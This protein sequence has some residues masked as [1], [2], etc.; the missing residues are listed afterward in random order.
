MSRE[1]VKVVTELVHES[2]K[3]YKVKAMLGN[4]VWLPKSQVSSCLRLPDN[5]VHLTLPYWLAEEKE[6]D[7]EE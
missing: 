6:L 4:D 7:Y 5:V 2:D 1:K 3:A